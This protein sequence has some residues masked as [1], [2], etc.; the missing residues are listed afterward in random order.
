MRHLFLSR[1]VLGLVLGTALLART[2]YAESQGNEYKGVTDP[3]GD[4]TN[5]EFAEDE[6]E[7]KE[8][9]HLGRY[10][11]L[12]VDFGL[13]AYTGGLGRT[14]SPGLFAG[15]RFQY[16]FDKSL[17]IEIRLHYFKSVDQVR[18]SGQSLD[19]ETTLI[20]ITGGFRYYFDTKNAPKAIA[21]ANP[22]V[23][24]G[25]G[26]YN[27][28]QTVVG[29][30]SGFTATEDSVTSNFGMNGGVGVEF[31]IYRRHIYLGADIRYHYIMFSDEDQAYVVE[32]DRS[33]DVFTS[34]ITLTYNF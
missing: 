1:F 14:N 26:V 22:Y 28:Q 6:K 29:T 16:F 11:M 32:G 31:N 20:P 34:L 27:R 5:Y 8:F 17:A 19:I 2:G 4:P 23:A 7:D 13:G 24:L 18:G 25:G 33:G 21:L 10:L 15:A 3:F 30:P 9:F 12:G